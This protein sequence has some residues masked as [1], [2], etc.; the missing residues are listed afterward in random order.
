MYKV[1]NLLSNQCILE[2]QGKSL[3]KKT[4]LDVLTLWKFLFDFIID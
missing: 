3:L 1:G 4:L 2:K